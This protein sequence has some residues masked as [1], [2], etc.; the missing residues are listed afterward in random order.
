MK[1]VLAIIAIVVASLILTFFY[2]GKALEAPENEI[3]NLPPLTG[4]RGP[5][6]EPGLGS[7]TSSP[8]TFSPPVFVGP[9]ASPQIIGPK[10]NPP[11]PAT[12][13]TG[14]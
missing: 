5:I 14:S 11:A 9:F 6:A 13:T 8:E 10:S 4:F 7:P 3:E 1:S 2:L 12:T